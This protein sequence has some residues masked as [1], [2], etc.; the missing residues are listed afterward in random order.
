MRGVIRLSMSFS[1]TLAMGERSEI[2]RYDEGKLAG[3]SGLC[4]GMM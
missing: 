2:G 4:I 3:L 1:R